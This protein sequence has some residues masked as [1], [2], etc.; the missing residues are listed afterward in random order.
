MYCFAISSRHYEKN[1]CLLLQMARCM[2][3][4]EEVT[5]G[6]SDTDEVNRVRVTVWLGK[7]D[8]R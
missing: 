5:S 3:E 6:V 1:T 2:I 7:R 8:P 4:Y